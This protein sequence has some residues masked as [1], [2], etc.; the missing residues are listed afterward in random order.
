MSQAAQDPTEDEPGLRPARPVRRV[1][2]RTWH[3]TFDDRILGLAAEAGFWALVSLPS[4]LLAI[5]GAIGYLRGMIGAEAVN[6]IRDDVLRAARDVLTP[7]TVSSDVAPILD[8][9]LARGHLEVMSIGFVISLW[10]GSTAMSDYLNTITVAYGMRGLR[11]AVRSRLVALWLYLCALVFGIVLLP[12]LAL[13]PDVITAL[14]PG[15]VHDEV[16]VTVHVV[17]WPVVAVGTVALLALLYKACLPVRVSWRRGL[18]GA[19]VA[20]VLWVVFSF[21]VR[22]WLTSSFRQ[23]SA[24]GSLSAP[25]AGLLFFYFTALAVL[26][27]AELNSAIDE[28]RPVRSTTDGR[29]RSIERA[30]TRHADAAAAPGRPVEPAGDP[31]VES[32]LPGGPAWAWSAAT[33]ATPPPGEWNDAIPPQEWHAG[34]AAGEWHGPPMAAPPPP[35]PSPA[36]GPVEARRRSRWLP[37]TEAVAGRPRR[38]RRS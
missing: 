9:V 4:M 11:G 15:N 14:F 28:V 5:F 36:R 27:G 29:Q 7:G 35:A 23:H 38:E 25:I 22:A 24:Y 2:A 20:M 18:P 33:A 21:V 8:Q 1:L 37:R 26:L 6:H 32:P 19:T 10:S 12:A 31:T 34:A 16:S 13:G 30:G 17:Y 3:K